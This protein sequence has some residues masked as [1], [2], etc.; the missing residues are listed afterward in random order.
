MTRR[1]VVYIALAASIVGRLDAQSPALPSDT[2]VRQILVDRIDRDHQS[3]GIVVGL[4]GS[5][6]RRV[7]AYGAVDKGGTRPLN[8]DTIFEIGSV[9]KVFTSLLLANMAA[10]NE[11]ALSDPIAKY[12]PS[13]V[14][15]PERGGRSITL[16][17]LSTHTSGLP[18]LPTNFS[19]KD[20]S[21]PY[22]DYSVDQLYQFLSSVQLTHDI[23]SQ[24]EYSNLGGGLL[25]HLLARRAGM[26]YEALVRSRIT[27]PLGMTSTSIM[28]VPEMKARLAAGHDQMLQPT[29]NWI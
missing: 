25:G 6:G 29:A 9:T 17:D 19:P 1:F 21:N 24:Y 14:K 4:V 2:E 13:Q 3:V 8:G 22:A 5:T 20:P 12:L 28:L 15:V 27:G 11:V 23:G 26:D 7:I 16:Q 18:R 10:R